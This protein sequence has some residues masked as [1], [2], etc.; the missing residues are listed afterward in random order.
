[1]IQLVPFGLNPKNKSLVDVHDVPRGRKCGCICPS[2]HTPLIARK[3]NEKKWHF[4]HAS[5]K[6]DA[7]DKEC[8]YSF[9]VSVRMMAKQI[10]H[11]G[12]SID[13]PKY[14]LTCL[15]EA[16]DRA[17]QKNY[18]VTQNSS[19]TLENV[20]KEHPFSGCIVDIAGKVGDFNFIIYLSH[21]NRNAPN[22]LDIPDCRNCGI[23]EINLN[24]TYDLLL[25]ERDIS[26]KSVDILED[27]LKH[28]TCSKHWIYHPRKKSMEEK[29]NNSIDNEIEKYF[30]NNNI[31]SK[32]K[33][34]KSTKPNNSLKMFECATC[35]I[36]WE[37]SSLEPPFCPNCYE[38]IF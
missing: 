22:K 26:V 13:L 1:M 23:I 36:K 16:H 7:T 9:F 33:P 20:K 6:I 2:C 27:F 34:T 19:I 25:S 31:R 28:N 21:D 32:I 5:R 8:D 3:G 10:I 24:D 11:T 29:A 18:I 30:S 37:V 35:H 15:K 38:Y 12:I 14:E 4:A 17:F